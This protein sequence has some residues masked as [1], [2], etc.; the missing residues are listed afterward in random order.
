MTVHL[1]THSPVGFGSC[2]RADYL[3]MGVFFIQFVE[4]AI[5]T[6]TRTHTHTTILHPSW[7]LIGTTQVSRY[8]KVKT[9][10]DLLEQEIVSGSGI[11][12]TICKSAPWP[13]QITMPAPH[14]SD[15]YRTD[16]FPAAFGDVGGSVPSHWRG[17]LGRVLFPSLL[18]SKCCC[19]QCFD[20]V[21]WASGL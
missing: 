14:H 5:H 20:D 18:Y 13:K 11:S 1:C 19:L 4:A 8:Q 12:W 16:A 10:L 15:F 3:L 17:D 2:Q 21:G 9:C 7:I 6:R